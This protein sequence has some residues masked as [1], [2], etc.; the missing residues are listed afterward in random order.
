MVDPPAGF[1]YVS[2][3]CY[4]AKI[5]PSILLL[6]HLYILLNYPWKALKKA[7]Y[8]FYSKHVLLET[9]FE[10]VLMFNREKVDIDFEEGQV[11]SFTALK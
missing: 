6:P 4:L 7:T 1:D 11:A 5:L 8:S 9:H 2:E 3:A 10:A